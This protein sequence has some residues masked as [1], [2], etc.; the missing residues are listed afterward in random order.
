MSASA[1]AEYSYSFNVVCG[2]RFR[3]HLS[4]CPLHERTCFLY[5]EVSRIKQQ[6]LPV[7]GTVILP[8]H[9]DHCYNEIFHW[10]ST[11]VPLSKECTKSEM[12]TLITDGE[13]HVNCSKTKFQHAAMHTRIEFRMSNRGKCI[14]HC[15]QMESLVVYSCIVLSTIER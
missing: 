10:E 6:E 4:D 15:Q 1:L 12:E 3:V 5:G 7:V 11:Q 14:S 9:L 8:L 2:Q 13:T